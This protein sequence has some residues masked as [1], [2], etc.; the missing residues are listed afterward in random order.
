MAWH[1]MEGKDR[2]GNGMEWVWYGMERT[3][4]ERKEMEGRKGKE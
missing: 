2:K 3:G 1:G 4:N